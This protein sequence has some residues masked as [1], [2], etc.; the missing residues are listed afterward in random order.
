VAAVLWETVGM[1]QYEHASIEQA[2]AN[3]AAARLNNKP[4]SEQI[5]LEA[6]KLRDTA[7]NLIEHAAT[8]I[9]RAAE[10]EKQIAGRNQ[11]RCFREGRDLECLYLLTPPYDSES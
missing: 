1:P 9:T 2:K 7:F 6:E 10:L 4:T 3:A 11:E 8:H 5:C